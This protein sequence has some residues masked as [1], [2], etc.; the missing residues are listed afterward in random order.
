MGGSA[1]GFSALAPILSVLPA[2]FAPPMLI[3]QHLHADDDGL[4]AEHLAR[5]ATLPVEEPCDKASIEGSHIYVAPA[6]YHLLVS[7]PA[8]ISLSIDAPVNYSRPAIDVLFES[9]ARVWSAA[10]VAVLLSGASNDGTAGMWAVKTNGGLAIA[11][12]PASA[13]FPLMPQSA[14]DAGVV[15]EI[16]SPQEIAARLLDL[17]SGGRRWPLA[18]KS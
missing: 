2:G 6:N 1:G 15:D 12:S 3:V 9:A 7:S 8:M 11:Q 13:E 10:L 14:I 18:K 4:F 16:L 5:I 17:A